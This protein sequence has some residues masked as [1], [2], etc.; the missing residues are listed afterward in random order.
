MAI[1]IDLAKAYDCVEWTILETMLHL[2][3]FSSKFINLI[4][5]CVST[6][7][8]SIL[9]NRSPFGYFSAG[10]GFRQGDPMS[11]ALFTIFSDLLSRM[12]AKAEMDGQISSV[13][14]AQT[15]PRITHLMY[16]DDVVIYCKASEAEARVVN[17][18]LQEYCHATGQE[19][20]WS[21]SSIHFIKN[22][23]RNTKRHLCRLLGMP[24]CD[25]RARYLGQ[26]FCNF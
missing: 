22:V 13:K 12:I 17:A 21:K 15:S 6:A 4:A 19:L 3:G 18:I 23:H 20:N 9:L 7:K 10:R 11:L 1:K 2:R 5:K 24:E 14:V 8:Y 16:A 26:P 25:H